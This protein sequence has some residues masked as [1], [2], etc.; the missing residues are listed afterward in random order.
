M[1]SGVM[2]MLSV[3]SVMSASDVITCAC[4]MSV[5]V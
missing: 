5:D 3:S 1:S 2:M 4:W